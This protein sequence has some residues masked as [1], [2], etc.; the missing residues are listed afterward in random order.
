MSNRIPSDRPFEDALGELESVVRDL[1]DGQ[2]GLDQAVA[3]YERGIAL[4]RHCHGHLQSAEQRILQLTS[5]DA[6]GQP[7]LQ[8]FRHE[9]TARAAALTRRRPADE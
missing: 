8:P 4:I 1:E 2:L 5:V 3:R 7:V 9:S 6:D